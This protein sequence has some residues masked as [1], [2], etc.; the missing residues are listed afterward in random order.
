MN[1]GG[2]E[3]ARFPIG[4]PTCSDLPRRQDAQVQV[5]AQR[6][7]KEQ[8]GK[9]VHRENKYKLYYTTAARNVAH[10]AQHAELD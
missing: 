6:T 3:C 7:H 8:D 2:R 5:S 9:P 10:I 4:L 1:L